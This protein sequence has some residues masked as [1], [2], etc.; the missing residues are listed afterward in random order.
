[1]NHASCAGW[2][3]VLK[4]TTKLVHSRICIIASFSLVQ[5]LYPPI[6][7][8]DAQ[9]PIDVELWGSCMLMEQFSRV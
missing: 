3:D 7:S 6:R 5:A 4:G 9:R 2:S 1:M 8:L